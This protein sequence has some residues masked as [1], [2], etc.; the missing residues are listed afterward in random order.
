MHVKRCDKTLWVP[1]GEQRTKQ[2]VWVWTYTADH[3][4]LNA[5]FMN[6][7][8]FPIVPEVTCI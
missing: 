5:R 6:F 3:I 2:L 8:T 4:T 1:S 7:T